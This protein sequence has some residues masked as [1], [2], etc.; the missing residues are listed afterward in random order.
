[1]EF[2]LINC[3]KSVHHEDSLQAKSRLGVP[4]RFLNLSLTLLFLSASTRGSYGS[5]SWRI[6]LMQKVMSNEDG[7]QAKINHILYKH[8][9][10]SVLKAFLMKLGLNCSLKFLP[11]TW[12]EDLVDIMRPDLRIPVQ[13]LV[14]HS[15][16]W[17]L[18]I[19]AALLSTKAFQDAWGYTIDIILDS[20]NLQHKADSILSTLNKR[21]IHLN[22][23][24]I[25]F[26]FYFPGFINITNKFWTLSAAFCWA[27][28]ISVM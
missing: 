25:G 8:L 7:K 1:M 24:T 2:H 9:M 6:C 15:S 5:C 19:Y 11:L 13:F 12:R 4:I 21:V 17:W 27:L 18:G 20:E 3:V 14:W 26:G 16:F 28:I 22:Y 23:F 10:L